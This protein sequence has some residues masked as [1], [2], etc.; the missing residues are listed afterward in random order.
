LFL[1]LRPLGDVLEH[2]NRACLRCS[3]N[4]RLKRDRGHVDQ[5]T[6]A[7]FAAA[8]DERQ[9]KNRGALRLVVDG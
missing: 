7:G 4:D 2:H 9:A 5:H 1:E 6:G 3:A 8:R